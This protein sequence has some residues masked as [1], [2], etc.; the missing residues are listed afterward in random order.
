M[1]IHK[2]RERLLGCA[3]ANGPPASFK[4]QLLPSHVQDVVVILTAGGVVPQLA[5]EA[6]CMSLA[7]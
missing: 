1:G 4:F 6:L 2:S 7:Q 5:G 3:V